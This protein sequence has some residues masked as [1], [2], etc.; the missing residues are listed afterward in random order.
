MKYIRWAVALAAI[1]TV[2][3]SVAGSQNA[4][5]ANSNPHPAILCRALEV[6]LDPKTAVTVVLFHQASKADGPTLG[7]VLKSNEGAP[8]EFVTSDSKPHQATL[9][10]LDTCFGRGL[11]V[12]PSATAHLS[13]HE[14][15]SIRIPVRG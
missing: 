13:T 9:F 6:K 12:F 2:A 11:L 8:V 10:R 3:A 5:P 14:Q 4:A 7:E 1:L 15:F